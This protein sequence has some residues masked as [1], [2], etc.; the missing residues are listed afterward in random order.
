MLTRAAL[1]QDA[2]LR[3]C[4]AYPLNP[5]GTSLLPAVCV[6]VFRSTLHVTLY[7]TWNISEASCLPDIA[8]L[9]RLFLFNNFSTFFVLLLW[10]CTT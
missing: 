3:L 7:P 4:V 2:L 8:E 1:K 10:L 9:C 6:A 5:L